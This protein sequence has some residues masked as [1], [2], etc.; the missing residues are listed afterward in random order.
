[1]L[2]QKLIFFLKIFLLFLNREYS[3]SYQNI[4]IFAG[5]KAYKNGIS[6]NNYSTYRKSGKGTV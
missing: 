2:Q 3:V 5:Q 1:M 6:T 4:I